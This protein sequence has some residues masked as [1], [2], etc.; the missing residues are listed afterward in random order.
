MG[1]RGAGTAGGG[2]GDVRDR[3]RGAFLGTLVGDALG[4]PLEGMPPAR[5]T[6]DD[7]PVR[8]MLEARSGRGTGTDDTQLTVALAEALLDW[9]PEAALDGEP[10][11]PLD[12]DPEPSLD[13]ERVPPL[14]L[15][16]VAE[17][18]GAHFD[19]AR[20]YGGNARRILEAVRAGDHWRKAVERHKLP[21]GSYGNGAAMRAAPAALAGFARVAWAVALADRQA[22]V[23]GH[24]HPVGR[25]G[26]R[27]QAAGVWAGLAHG[28]GAPFEPGAALRRAEAGGEPLEAPGAF[29][30]AVD[31]L[32]EHRDA[33]PEEAAEALGTGS[34]ADRSVP[35]AFWAVAAHPDDPVEALVA[36][37]NLGGDADTI[38]AMAGALA[39][40]RNGAK[41]FPHR[42]VEALEEGA[43]GRERL[44]ELADAL[45][46]RFG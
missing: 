38:G 7:G 17:R 15:D 31:W 9:E 40:A 18:F 11:P 3:F 39:G 21:G 43:M 14:D 37:V 36:A 8:E 16:R 24:T 27:L 23:T 33:P 42:W 30:E 19:P 10:D 46:E 25:F 5:G 22:A 44:L 1:D 13:L 29:R 2:A 12:G 20:G 6:Q 34:R 35:A 4:M 45:Y 32:E 41:A 26:A 28:T